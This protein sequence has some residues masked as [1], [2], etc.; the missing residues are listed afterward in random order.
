MEKPLYRLE[1]EEILK[2]FGGKHIIS[3][4]EVQQYTGKG[5]YWCTKHIP[6]PHNGCTAVQLAHA[7]A[8]LGQNKNRFYT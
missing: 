5:K 2:A 3:F 1:L 6:V 4:A 8:N 7:L